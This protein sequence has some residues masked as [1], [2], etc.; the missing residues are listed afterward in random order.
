MTGAPRGDCLEVGGPEAQET[1]ASV[2][3]DNRD[4]T[5]SFDL[6]ALAGLAPPD[7][8]EVTLQHL[9]RTQRKQRWLAMSRPWSGRSI[10]ARAPVNGGAI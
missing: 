10:P 9:Q 3:I 6:P 7:E 8:R 1:I 4:G 2:T 5:R